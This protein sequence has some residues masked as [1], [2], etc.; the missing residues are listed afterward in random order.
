MINKRNAIINAIFT[1]SGMKCR[2]MLA[3]FSG[4]GRKMDDRCIASITFVEANHYAASAYTVLQQIS[5][6]SQGNRS[7]T[8]EEG[9]YR[10]EQN[11]D[12]ERN[13]G[14]LRVSSPK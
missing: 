3:G 10:K 13:Y 8:R 12:D 9:S 6:S 1:H 4:V 7:E 2:D 5:P 14:D 11:A